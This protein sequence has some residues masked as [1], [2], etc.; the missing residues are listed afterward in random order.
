MT[1]FRWREAVVGGGAYTKFGDLNVRIYPTYGYDG[2]PFKWVIR[3]G[4]QATGKIVAGG[5]GITLDIAKQQAE[6]SLS[7]ELGGEWCGMPL[8]YVFDPEYPHGQEVRLPAWVARIVVRVAP[9]LTMWPVRRSET[10]V[11]QRFFGDP[12]AQ[13]P[14]AEA[15]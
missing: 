2:P 12:A 10:P 15:A 7:Y 8:T 5:Q 4:D 14:E 9:H 1:R 11:H 6:A 3:R 13:D